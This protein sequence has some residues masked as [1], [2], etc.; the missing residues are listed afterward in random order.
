MNRQLFAGCNARTRTALY[1]ILP[2]AVHLTYCSG[3]VVLIDKTIASVH[4]LDSRV[5]ES[6]C[7]SLLDKSAVFEEIQIPVASD[8]GLLRRVG[9]SLVAVSFLFP[10]AVRMRMSM[11]LCMCI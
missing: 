8:D 6:P 2:N 10:F 4:A 9:E 1:H 7:F 5:Q 3:L 11:H